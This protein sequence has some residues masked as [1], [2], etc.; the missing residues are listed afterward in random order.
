LLKATTAA[1]ILTTLLCASA[2][3]ATRSQ[4]AS[5]AMPVNRDGV[6]KATGDKRCHVWVFAIKDTAVDGDAITCVDH[7][8]TACSCDTN[9]TILQQL[10]GGCR[11]HQVDACGQL[12]RHTHE[13]MAVGGLHEASTKMNALKDLLTG[14][15]AD[16]CHT[17]TYTSGEVQLSAR[18]LHSRQIGI[19]RCILHRKAIG[20][21]GSDHSA[22]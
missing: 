15:G 14:I 21:A 4:C 2:I 16:S 9:N 12:N 6:L 3:R 22:I 17:G 13:A 5:E 7:G 18:S 1:M 19:I 20:A 8:L 11:Q 10:H